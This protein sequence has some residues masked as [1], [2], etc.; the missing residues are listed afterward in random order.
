[1]KIT[2]LG[3]ATLQIEVD[4]KIII[5]TDDKKSCV[6]F[7]EKQNRY[8]YTIVSNNPI[9]DFWLLV[10]AQTLICAPSTFSFWAAIVGVKGQKVIAPMSFTRYVKT[11]PL[12]W[13]LI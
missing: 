1:M 10:S 5:V 7:M 9:D 12:N 3:H 2:F 13:E 4:D 6:S 8:N 11:V